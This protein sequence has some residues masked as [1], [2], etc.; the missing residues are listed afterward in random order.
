MNPS[1]VK[2]V[3]EKDSSSLLRILT[4]LAKETGLDFV[5]VTDDKGTVIVR[6]HEQSKGDSIA[7]QTN[8]QHALK[9]AVFGAVEAG[10]VIKFSA[11]AGAP[12]KNEQGQ[13]LGVVSGGYDLTKD[14]FIDGVKKKYGTDVTLFLGDERVATTLVKDGKRVIGSKLDAEISAQV[15]GK[16]AEIQHQGKHPRHGLFYG[17][18]SDKWGG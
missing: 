9:G 2:A 4:P 16:G 1:V 10:T 8:V 17:I 7:N 12:V 3:A 11:R 6:I 5:T 15:L 18:S 13:V 14:A